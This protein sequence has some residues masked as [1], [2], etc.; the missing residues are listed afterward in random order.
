MERICSSAPSCTLLIMSHI[1][2]KEPVISTLTA[3]LLPKSLPQFVQWQ[4]AFAN[5]IASSEGFV[6]LEFLAK[7]NEPYSW[8]IVQRFYSR[9]NA[10][11]WKTSPSYEQLIDELKPLLAAKQLRE[12]IQ[13]EAD[14]T[15]GVTEVI[16]TQ[17]DPHHEQAYMEWSSKIHQVEAQFEGFRG[18]YIQSPKSN[19]GRHWITLLQF[20]TP[21]H[22]DTWLNSEERKNILK[23]GMPLISSLETSRMASPFAGWFSSI[24]KGE[25][26]PSVWQQTMIVLLILFPIVMLE[27]KYLSP[28]TAHLNNSL[29]TFIGNT[30]S[31]TLI[32]YPFMPIV[33]PLLKWW[34]YPS[35]RTSWPSLYFGTLFILFLY[36]LEVLL[37]WNFL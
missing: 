27:L 7:P 15:S 12:E 35:H 24:A 28:W 9:D 3:R 25:E 30:I 22:L 5:R 13:N 31:V 16:I 4:S 1:E 20:D 14:L 37:F 10:S 32:A 21:A 19:G 17:I 33:L 26:A 6:S 8:M 18:V 36:F 11:N 23:E 29:A 34:L 2:I